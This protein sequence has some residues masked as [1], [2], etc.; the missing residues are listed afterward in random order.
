[1]DQQLGQRIRVVGT[2]GSGKTTLAQR[3][4]G[5]L[6]VPHIELDALH[7]DPGWQ[8]AHPDV[9]ARRIA[10]ATSADAW[11]MDGNYSA[12]AARIVPWDRVDAL[13]FLDYPLRV[14]LWRVV[15]RTFLRAMTGVELWNG[16][17]ERWQ[18]TF[19][20]DSIILWSLTT[21]HRRRRQYRALIDSPEMAG[22][23]VVHL[24]SPREANRW[25]SRIQHRIRAGSAGGSDRKRP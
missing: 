21:Y 20:R 12:V 8:M 25:L 14:V 24:R 13:I 19:S 3:L 9:F 5:R 4:A 23:R 17:R 18:E 6:G 2:S 22:V 7:W 16:N 15:T 10:E 11:V 1:V